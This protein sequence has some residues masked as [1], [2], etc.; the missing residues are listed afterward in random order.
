VFY[1]A[2]TVHPMPA[3]GLFHRL[4]RRA[5][6]VLDRRF[7]TVVDHTDALGPRIDE[8]TR[9]LDAFGAEL[10]ALRGELAAVRAE[11]GAELTDVREWLAPV[12]RAVVTQ[13]AANRRRLEQIR[14]EPEYTLPFEHPD[15]LVTVSIPTHD[16]VELLTE[17]ALPSVLAQTHERLEVIV[18][19][20]AAPPHVA[21][22]IEAIGDE[23]VRFVNL[24]HRH[25]ATAAEHH[26]L[27]GSVPAR[28]AGYAHATGHW[29]VD[30]DDDDAMRPDAI[31]R[32]LAKAREERLEVVYG[33]LEAHFADGGTEVIGRFPPTV[34]QFGWQ[35][36]VVHNGLRFLGRELVAASFG[37][38]N[39]WFRVETMMRIG[40][41]FGMVDEILYDYYPAR[42]WNRE[43]PVPEN[44]FI[45]EH[46]W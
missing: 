7:Q 1:Q 26:W 44:A 18:V 40:V 12:L 16:R 42:S 38:P 43:T 32:V 15:P 6:W 28:N 30:F 19:G 24:T 45:E 3:S 8:V 2:D 31:E 37:Q 5:A 11:L 4:R 25:A 10:V 9:R 34:H 23:R 27:V 14:T 36:A 13:E 39:D 41:R 35:G 46:A 33:K 22:A 17:R 21:A 29:I 20:D